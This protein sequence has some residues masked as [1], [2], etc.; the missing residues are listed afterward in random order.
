MVELGLVTSLMYGTVRLRLK[1]VLKPWRQQQWRIPKVV[2]ADVDQQNGLTAVIDPPWK[3][4]NAIDI[5]SLFVGQSPPLKPAVLGVA[6]ADPGNW[7]YFA[8]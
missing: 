7:R 8:C 4:G 1:N 2:N 3:H 5:R 6:T